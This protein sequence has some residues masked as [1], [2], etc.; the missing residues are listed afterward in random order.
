MYL[1]HFGMTACPL[2]K[3]VKPLFDDGQL[4]RLQERFNWL[5]DYPGLGLFTGEV[6]VGKTAA[7]RHLTQSL[8][9]HRYR[10]IYTDS[11]DCSR[12]DL[13]NSLALALNLEPA[14]RIMSLWQDIK[15]RLLELADNKQIQVIWIIDEAQNLPKEFYR[16][17]SSFLS[18]D[19][20]SRDVMTVWL[21]GQPKLLLQVDKAVNESIASRIQVRLQ[22][23]SMIEPNR[24]RALIEHGFKVVGCEH[25]LLSDSGF[26]ML[27][28]ASQGKPRLAC[29]VLKASLR[30]AASKG[31]N[32]L[33]DELI[34]QA[35]ESLK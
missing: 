21:A 16:D 8:N 11:T 34:E 6:G 5:V 25:T 14:F 27:R 20:D 23:P 24:F 33:P 28:Q 22:L 18:I 3:N 12:R 17:F 10:V 31:L 29:L 13:Y 1:K 9:P 7:L 2:D 26:E 32:H 15:S 19:F 30:L 35:V 4:S